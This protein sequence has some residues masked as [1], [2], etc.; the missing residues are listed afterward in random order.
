VRAGGVAVLSA[1]PMIC[2]LDGLTAHDDDF[3][4]VGIDGF[5]PLRAGC[6]PGCRRACSSCP[7]RHPPYVADEAVATRRFHCR[8]RL[9]VNP[10]VPAGR[11]S[12]N[13]RALAELLV[14]IRT[15]GHFIR[16]P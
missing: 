7:C 12:V 2:P 4:Q 8:W 14:M 3:L 13:L 9:E 16:K 11:I 1:R 15:G 5:V 6:A 10:L